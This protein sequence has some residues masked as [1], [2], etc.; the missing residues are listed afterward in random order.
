LKALGTVIPELLLGT[1][2]A[3]ACI[4]LFAAGEARGLL[5]LLLVGGL[6]KSAKYLLAPLLAILA[7]YGIHERADGALPA[8]QAAP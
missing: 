4:G 3:G 5:V 1:T 2:L 6:L 8:P 7:E